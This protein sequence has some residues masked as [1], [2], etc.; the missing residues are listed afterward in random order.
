MS[1]DTSSAPP[2][3]CEDRNA[4]VI[5][6]SVGHHVGPAEQLRLHIEAKSPAHTRVWAG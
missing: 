3:A 4:T 5:A 6:A 1:L 2:L